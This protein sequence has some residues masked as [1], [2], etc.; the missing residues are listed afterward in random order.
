M[1]IAVCVSGQA[2]TWE[3]CKENIKKVFTDTDDYQFDFFIHTWDRNDFNFINDDFG[4]HPIQNSKNVPLILSI[5][6]MPLFPIHSTPFRHPQPPQT[7]KPY[8]DNIS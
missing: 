7:D 3:Y 6:Y 4:I 2:R 8:P 1:K 5:P